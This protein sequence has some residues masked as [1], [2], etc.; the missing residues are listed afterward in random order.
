MKFATFIRSYNMALSS[1]LDKTKDWPGIYLRN[2]VL[3][4]NSIQQISFVFANAENVTP[5]TLGLKIA[6]DCSTIDK[7]KDELD[8]LSN[9]SL[10]SVSPDKLAQEAV[11]Q[12]LGLTEAGRVFYIIKVVETKIIQMATDIEEVE[13]ANIYFDYDKDMLVLDLTS[14]DDS[15]SVRSDGVIT[16]FG[17]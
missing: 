17:F 14:D 11:D 2:L 13:L 5:S 15:L 9:K 12:G 8:E 7:Y 3:P 1:I 4:D 6:F 16:L 10:G